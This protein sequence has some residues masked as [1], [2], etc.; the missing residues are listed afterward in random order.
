MAQAS[1]KPPKL[2]RKEILFLK[3]VAKGKTGTEAALVAYDTNDPNTAAVISSENLRKPKLK[4]ALE[5]AYDKAGITAQ[6]IADVLSDAMLATKTATVAGEVIPSTQP[7]HGVRVT[8]ARTAAQLIGAGKDPDDPS[9]GP[10]FNFQ[11]NNYI[12]QVD[13]RP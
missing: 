10:T 6:S 3:E 4:E 2:T 5:Q 7:D 1:T 13:V 11:T 8:A 12:K 9:G